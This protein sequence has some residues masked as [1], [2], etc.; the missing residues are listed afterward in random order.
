M[1]C[2]VQ[3]Q[4]IREILK[5]I[6]SSKLE[7]L[8]IFLSLYYFSEFYS[9]SLSFF[10]YVYIYVYI[11]YVYYTHTHIYKITKQYLILIFELYL[12]N[13]YVFSRALLLSALLLAFIHIKWSVSFILCCIP[14]F[15]SP[16]LCIH[17]TALKI[18]IVSRFC[19]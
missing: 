15:N 18:W 16:H 2:F 14:L 13:L 19:P 3:V 11:I 12:W 10:V 6:S 8:M 9:P 5:N 17:S 1:W 7:S 4:L